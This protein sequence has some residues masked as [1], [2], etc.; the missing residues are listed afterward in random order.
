[1]A[2]NTESFPKSST[3]RTTAK[4]QYIDLCGPIKPESHSHKRYFLTFIDNFSR[5]TWVFFLVE[6][7]EAFEI[8]KK[9]KALIE[10]EIGNTIACL[11]TNR[12]GEFTSKSNSMNV[13]SRKAS[14]GS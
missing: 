11:R 12:R 14:K 3:W 8:F 7:S 13:T 9:L 1:M 6:K 5:K 4:L 2:S 10:K